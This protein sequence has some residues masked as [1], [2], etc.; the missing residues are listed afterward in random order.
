MRSRPIV[1]NI[2]AAVKTFDANIGNFVLMWK[3]LDL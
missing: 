2:F 3:K 1:G